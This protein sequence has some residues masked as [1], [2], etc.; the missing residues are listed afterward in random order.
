MS[1]IAHPS[2]RR[3]ASELVGNLRRP[4]LIALAYYAGAEAAFAIGTLSDRIFA[5]FWPP[6]IILCCALL[7]APARLWWLYLLAVF[8]AHVIAELRVGMPVPQMLVA[9]AT[10]GVIAVAGA[11]A[12]RHF[13]GEPPWFDSIRKAGLYVLISAVVLPAVVAL[14][15]AFVP[16]LGGGGIQH[17]WL[18]WMQWCLSNTVSNLA[19]GPAILVWVVHRRMLRNLTTGEIVEGLLLIGG[20]FLVCAVVFTKAANSAASGLFPALLYLPLPLIVW[21][22]IRFGQ[23]GASSAILVVTVTLLW[24]A[25]NG[26]SL[27][28]AETPDASVFAIQ[29]FVVGLAVPVLLLGAAIDETRRAERATRESEER[30]AFAAI[31]AD[32]CMW[33]FNY[34]SEGFWITSHGRQMLGFTADEPVTRQTFLDTLHPDD[35]EA[36]REAIRSAASAGHLADVEFR[37]VRRDGSV[38]WFRARARADRDET[39]EIREISGTFADVTNRKASENEL[40]QQRRDLAHLMRVSM[41]GELSGGIAHELAQPLTAILSNAQAARMLMDNE[42]VDLPEV[43]AALDDIISEDNRA[44]EIIHRMRGL[45][46]RGETRV[47]PVDLNALIR[48]SLRLLNSELIARRIKCQCDLSESL[49]LA[50]GDPVQ[51]QQVLLNLV[52]NAVEAMNEVASSRRIVSLRTTATEDGRICIT[53]SDCGVGLTPPDEERLFQPFFTTKER[54]LGLGLTICTSI[55]KSHGGTLKL[56]NN[57]TGGATATVLISGEHTSIAA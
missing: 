4:V 30:M 45:L 50:P 16:V 14:G 51:L 52:M 54:G 15:G 5:P 35:R 28:I 3:P 11:A 13:I 17:Y 24:S 34:K 31:A 47:E 32:L 39:G 9:F 29:A 37:V 48:S 7:F 26:Q 19:L 1:S 21:S 36:A 55:V 44:G 22:A 6:N 46:R 42:P 57:K 23:V 38:R 20:L 41:L 10:N 18:F 25:L 40:A 56:E 53:V 33:H 12:I 8:P 43:S 27:F 49:P 2:I